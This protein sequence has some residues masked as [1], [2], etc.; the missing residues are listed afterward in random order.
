MTQLWSG[1]KKYL[2]KANKTGAGNI[3]MSEW[4]VMMRKDSWFND[5]DEWIIWYLAG[6]GEHA[7]L[8]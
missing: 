6:S 4:L 8:G 1:E 5:L 3:K 2:Q 7:G